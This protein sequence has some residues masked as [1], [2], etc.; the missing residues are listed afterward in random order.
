MKLRVVE[1]AGMGHETPVEDVPG[2]ADYYFESRETKV[3]KWVGGLPG[4]EGLCLRKLF[5][6]QSFPSA[7]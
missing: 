6:L 4:P 2:Q 5:F 3:D 7:V 1:R